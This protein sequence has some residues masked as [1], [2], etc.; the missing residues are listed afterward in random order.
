MKMWKLFC[1]ICFAALC[2]ICNAQRKDDSDIASR[3]AVENEGEVVL[4]DTGLHCFVIR[5]RT[6]NETKFFAPEMKLKMIEPG[7]RI[8]ITYKKTTD[9]K[10][11]ALGIKERKSMKKQKIPEVSL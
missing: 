5:D 10:L 9:G 6:G 2:L 11:K 8:Q 4:I 3:N 7:K 1:L